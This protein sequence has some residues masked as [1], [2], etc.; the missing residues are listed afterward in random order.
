MGEEPATR[1]DQLPYSP[2]IPLRPPPGPRLW[3][4]ALTEHLLAPLR[5]WLVAVDPLEVAAAHAV[6]HGGDT[7]ARARSTE[8]C[9]PVAGCPL[10]A[11]T[12]GPGR[13]RGGG[14]GRGFG[15]SWAD[16]GRV[17]VVPPE[18]KKSGL[19][20][21]AV[22][23]P[24]QPCRSHCGT[25]RVLDSLTAWRCPLPL[26]GCALRCAPVSAPG[27]PHHGAP[28]TLCSRRGP[29]GLLILASWSP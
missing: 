15:A 28:F 22:P 8:L 16:L 25:P 9:S 29:L 3:S 14:R 10:L 2:P 6:A 19:E 27:W 13:G 21:A 12:S 20:D 18:P 4:H 17:A 26:A 5:V 24:W 11:G 1:A 7:G 23:A